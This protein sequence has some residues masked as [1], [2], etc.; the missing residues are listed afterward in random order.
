MATLPVT[1]YVLGAALSAMPVAW[2]QARVGRKRSFQIGL[3]VAMAASA[4]CALAVSSRKLLAAAVATVVAGFYS[5]NGGAVPFRRPRA[6]GPGL[7]GA[8]HLLVLAGGIVGAFI[9]PNLASAS[10]DW[11]AVPFAGAYLALVGVALLSLLAMSLHPELSR[12]M[13]RRREGCLG[14]SAPGRIDAAAGV[15]RR[16]GWPP[17]WATG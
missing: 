1:G 3:L 10:R 15:R 17:R 12:R 4:L 5:A 9:G 8:R 16:R 14:G 6:G 11:L 7:Q 2:M 13:W